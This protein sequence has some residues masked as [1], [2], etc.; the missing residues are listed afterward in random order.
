MYV[1]K[2]YYIYCAKS[3][4]NCTLSFLYIHSINPLSKAMGKRWVG[5]KNLEP[6]SMKVP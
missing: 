2:K 3:R 1:E 4:A 6:Y 5:A